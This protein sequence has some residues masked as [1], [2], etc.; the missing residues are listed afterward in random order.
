MVDLTK[1]LEFFDP[2]ILKT[3]NIHIIGVGAIGSTIAEM[4]TRLGVD[5]IHIYDFDKV[6]TQNVA[7]QMYTSKSVGQLKVDALEEFLKLINPNIEIIKHTEGWTSDTPLN[8]YVFLSVD[9]IETRKQIVTLNKFN[10]HILA[11]F[12]FRMRLTDAQHYATDWK[13][14]VEVEQFFK[15]MDF[16]EEE[17]KNATP[18]SACGTTLSVAPTIRTIVSLGIANWIN[19]IKTKKL[20]KV[21]LIDAFEFLLDTF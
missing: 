4:L 7:N 20:K 3:Q 14:K 8:G 12:D 2:T 21:I 9:N 18:I 17:A 5:K 6:E 11:M 13:N 10:Q 19:F 16:S 1:S 15:T